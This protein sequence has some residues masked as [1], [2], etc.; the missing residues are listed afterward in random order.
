MVTIL[1]IP[2]KSR[3]LPPG[4]NLYMKEYVADGRF[5]CGLFE[6]HS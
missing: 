2:K 3:F 4:G 5:L 6:Q 1:G